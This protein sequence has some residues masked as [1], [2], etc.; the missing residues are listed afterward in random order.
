MMAE[1]FDRQAVINAAL[2]DGVLDID[3]LLTCNDF[4]TIEEGLTNYPLLIDEYLKGEYR[5]GNF[6]LVYRWAVDHNWNQGIR[7]FL[8]FN[9]VDRNDEIDRGFD[10]ELDKRLAEMRRSG[11]KFTNDH[12]FYDGRRSYDYRT[13]SRK[14][15]VEKILGELRSELDKEAITSGLTREYFE[16]LLDDGNLELLVIK[17]CVRLEA[18]L[19][20]DFRYEGTFEEMLSKYSHDH[21]YE[22]VDVGWGC[23]EN[24]E[25]DSSVIFHKLRKYRNDIVHA[26]KKQEC[27]TKEEL[28][29]AIDLV[30][31][32]G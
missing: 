13:S 15:V 8:R 6:R 14:Q 29:I 7:F 23:I 12:Y 17:L 3:K 25:T 30:C 4:P 21:G 28:E 20:C 11:T 24:G 26:E 27:M 10:S 2:K 18:I 1:A 22:N 32:L 5:K 31:S 9:S 16:R 19:K